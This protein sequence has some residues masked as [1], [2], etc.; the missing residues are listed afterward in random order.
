MEQRQKSFIHRIQTI[1]EME[2]NKE[3]N[4][5]GGFDQWARNFPILNTIMHFLQWFIVP[6]ETLLRR[7]FGQRYYTKIN[8]YV[9]FI[10]LLWLNLIQQIGG[11]VGAVLGGISN[12]VNQRDYEGEPSF[13]DSV[14]PKLPLLLLLAY[15]ALGSYH[16]FKIRWRNYNGMYEHSFEDGT[17]RL[18]FLASGFMDLINAISKPITSLYMMFLPARQRNAGNKVPPRFN[19]LTAFTNTFFEPFFLFVVAILLAVIGAGFISI[20]L[21]LSSFALAIFANWRETAKLNRLLD[22]LD[23]MVDAS[24]QKRLIRGEPTER[25]TVAQREIV[26]QIAQKAEEDPAAAQQ[27]KDDYPDLMQMMEEMNAPKKTL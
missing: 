6:M 3:R 27:V 23:S 1:L 26:A 19:D 20:F 13:I 15:L 25:I 16:F 24:D 8:F 11:V 18:T 17:S 7:D 5:F 21:M 2:G 10:V 9:G 14:I 4:V 12:M 22:S